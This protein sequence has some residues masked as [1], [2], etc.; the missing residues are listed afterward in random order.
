ME[1]IYVLDYRFARTPDGIVWTDTDY[2]E[3]FWGRYL[4]T[5]D[6]VRIVSR[7]RETPLAKPEWRRV[8]GK[9]VSV[10]AVP[11]YLGPYEYLARARKVRCAVK[12]ALAR[13][14][15]AVILRAPSQISTCCASLLYSRRRPYGVEVVGDPYESLG[16]GRVR[17]FLRPIFRLWYSV[18][19]KRQC[20]NARGAA[21]VAEGLQARYPARAGALSIVCSDVHLPDEAFVEC[22]RAH[23]RKDTFR[24]ITVASLSQLYKGVDILI[25]AAAECARSGLNL[26]LTIMGDGKHRRDLEARA[27]SLNLGSRIKFLGNLP[28][29]AAVRAQLDCADLF[30]L[31]SRAEGTPRAML[32]AMARALP[33]IGSAVGAIPVLL[34][35]DDLVRTGDVAA[36]AKKIREVVEDRERMDL[37]SRRNLETARGYLEAVLQPEREKFYQFVRGET[38]KWIDAGSFAPAGRSL[39]NYAGP[40]RH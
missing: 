12:V 9:S 35:A 22:G 13:P 40:S 17:H 6:R 20:A 4:K 39:H 19:Q 5:F 26:T 15:A 11:Y 14:D 30:V 3:P 28:A 16:P 27:A 1:L 32:E 7:V 24:I 31:A 8:D 33:C 36:V 23:R 25:E 18:Q 21:Y 34:A 29:G 37:M 10:E 38:R 2:D